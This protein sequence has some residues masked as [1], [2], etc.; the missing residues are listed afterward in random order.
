MP[1]QRKINIRPAMGGPPNAGF[2]PDELAAQT[3]DQI[4]WSNRDKVAHWPGLLNDDGSI[5]AT[6][7]MPNQ[8]A[9]D[10]DVSPIFSPSAPATFK[11]ACSL[12]P[13]E[14]GTITVT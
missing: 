1:N 12:H 5:D 14:Q 11:Y 4:F 10:G 9:P 3:R 6:F 7:F 8:I 13:D 2:D